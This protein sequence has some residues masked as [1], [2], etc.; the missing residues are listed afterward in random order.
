MQHHDYD[1]PGRIAGPCIIEGMPN[2]QYHDYAR[3]RA[4]GNSGLQLMLDCPALFHGQYIDPLRPKKEDKETPGRL[5]GNM[6]HCVLFEHD[7]FARR[8]RV[9]PE[10]HSKNLKVWQDFKKECEAS[11][12]S[13]I[14]S[15]QYASAMKVRENAMAIPDLREALLHPGGRGEASIFAKDP[16]M[17]VL[18][19]IRPDWDMPLGDKRAVLWD[20]KS[21]ATGDADEF[22][23]QAARM[24]Y[25]FQAAFYTDFYTAGTGK[26]VAAFIHIVIADEW[27]HPI[28]L[29]QLGERSIK[30]GRAK[31]R[32]ALDI[33]A[34]C[35][36][37]GVWPGYAPG[38]KLVEMPNYAL[39]EA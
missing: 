29:V 2:E 23:R 4:V 37:T 14:D 7:A 26:D 9:G 18:C 24:G 15:A 21:F 13:A 17:G 11:A 12:A 16:R 32:R 38:I 31:Y 27:P 5:F 30:S 19:K 6:V 34:E 8:Y 22:A 25:D 36:R 10:V 3:T 39:E 28:N 33:Y 1:E 20:A 35:L